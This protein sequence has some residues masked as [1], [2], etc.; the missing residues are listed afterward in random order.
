MSSEPFS[1][2]SSESS[3]L[4][5]SN[6]LSSSNSIDVDLTEL[7]STMVYSE[8]YNM[9]AAP[10]DYVGKTVKM[11]GEFTLYSDKISG[12]NYFAVVIADA[13]ACC[14]QGLE[15]VLGN[16][17]VYPNDYPKEQAEITIQ[18]VFEIYDEGQFQYCHL[19]NA[20]IV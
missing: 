18:G 10:K 5:Q 12:K 9:M 20:K 15:F 6:A 2:S 8:V 3:R 4:K 1:D 14:S 13:A 19:V 16:D 7:S 11:K 17:A